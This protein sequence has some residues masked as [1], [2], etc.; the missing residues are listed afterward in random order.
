MATTTRLI[1]TRSWSGLSAITS[2][3]VEQLGLAMMLRLVYPAMAWPLTSG[4]TRGTSGSMRKCE[5]LSMTT[6][7]AAAARGLCTAETLAPGEDS[8]ISMPAKSKPA[9]SRTFRTASSPNDSSLPTDLS[10]ASAMTS[11]A[12]KSRSARVARISRPTLPVAPT[13]AIR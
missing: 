5:V 9:R 11:S 4:T 7:P 6:A 8:T 2:W 13:T 12:G 1:F 3:M 10:D